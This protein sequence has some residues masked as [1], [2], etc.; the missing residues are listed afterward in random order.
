MENFVVVYSPSINTNFVSWNHDKRGTGLI[1]SLGFCSVQSYIACTK[2]ASRKA[3]LSRPRAPHMV[4]TW[5]EFGRHRSFSFATLEQFFQDSDQTIHWPRQVPK[6]SPT[7]PPL[8]NKR[9]H[10]HPFHSDSLSNNCKRTLRTAVM[11]FVEKGNLPIISDSV[12]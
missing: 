2:P 6:H 10:F 3:A 8:P 12:R 1:T 7:P 9:K 5:S 11:I 4:L